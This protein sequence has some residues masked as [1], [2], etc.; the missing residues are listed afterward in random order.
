VQHGKSD[1]SELFFEDLKDYV[2][3]CGPV[4]KLSGKGESSMYVACGIPQTEMLAIEK[5]M[6]KAGCDLRVVQLAPVSVLNAFVASQAE[7]AAKEAFILVDFGR[8]RMTVIGGSGGIVNVMRWMN[9]PWGEVPASLISPVTSED[10]ATN[11]SEG[12]DEA[13][14]AVFSE[15]ANLLASELK[16]VLESFRMQGDS[17]SFGRIYIS[18]ELSNHKALI[19]G[20]THELQLQCTPWNPFRHI[21]AHHKALKDFTL[22]SEV[23]HLTGA[24]GAA[25]QCVA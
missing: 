11:D 20:L 2:T 3:Q 5:A 19:N 15:V 16:P 23:A 8:S 21:A 4:A 7:A 6:A 24:A 22:L 25:Y 10:T 1:A 12:V 13:L 14:S 18:G 9:Y 17:V